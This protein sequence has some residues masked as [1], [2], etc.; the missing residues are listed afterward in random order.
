M[1]TD[2]KRQR[3]KLNNILHIISTQAYISQHQPSNISETLRAV[4]TSLL[5]IFWQE[6]YNSNNNSIL[7]A[8]DSGKT[9]PLLL[10][11]IS[12]YLLRIVSSFH[13]RTKNN[14][15]KILLTNCLYNCCYRLHN[16]LSPKQRAKRM[17][18]VRPFF[19]I[20]KFKTNLRSIEGCEF[21][22]DWL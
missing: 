7:P 20:F 12:F 9:G 11:L 13:P 6:F 17:L 15:L 21:K 8:N 2:T 18:S 14:D 4:L 5:C 19:Q 3:I 1:P 22:I 10:L 16:L